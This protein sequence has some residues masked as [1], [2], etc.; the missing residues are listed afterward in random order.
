MK[1]DKLSAAFLDITFL[2]QLFQ[3]DITVEAFNLNGFKGFLAEL[4]EVHFSELSIFESKAKLF[5]LSRKNS[6][7]TQG[8]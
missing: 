5:R 3:L 6:A 8:P 7:Y 2:L 1:Q 4:P